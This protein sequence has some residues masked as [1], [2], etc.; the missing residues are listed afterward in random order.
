MPKFI[1]RFFRLSL[2]VS[3]VAAVNVGSIFPVQ[4]QDGRD[5]LGFA[6]SEICVPGIIDVPT[7]LQE[8]PPGEYEYQS[9]N[10]EGDEIETTD[11]DEILLSGNAQVVQGDRG[12]Y[13]DEIRF[14]KET[15]E[16]NANGNV[17]FYTGNGDEIRADSLD[18]VVDTFIGSAEDATIQF[19]DISPYF[20]EREHYNFEE[21]YSIFAP[22]RN[23][24]IEL[25]A[26]TG[27]PIDTNTY[28]RARATAETIE[29]EG[30]DFQ[31]MKNT[32][33]TT[34]TE[35]NG[36]ILLV[37]KEIELDHVTGIG[38]AKSMTVK[39]KK[40]PIFYFPTVS[41]P[42]NDERKTGF[43]FPGFGYDD[44][45]GTILA[46]PY[47]I[48]ISPQQDAT[49]TPRLLS[50]RGVQLYGEYRYLTHSSR[51]QIKVEYLPG[52]DLFDDDRHALSFDHY[53]SFNKDWNAD[54]DLQD[55]S[56]T[57]YLSDFATDVDVANATYIPQTANLNYFG[58]NL[59]FKAV[60]S[61][62]QRVN[63]SVSV[64]NQPYARLPQITLDLKAQEFSAF[65][66]GIDSQLTDF[67]HED[68]IS[69]EG[70]RARIL[71]YLTLPLEEIYG[72]VKPRVSVQAI[73]YDLDNNPTGESSPSTTVP[74]ASID[75]GLFFERIFKRSDKVFLHTLEPRL[76]YLNIPTELEQNDF[77]D[78]DTSG[79]SNSSYSHYFR[80]NRFFGG[81]RVGDAHQLSVG[82]SSRIIDDD[83]GV[84]RMNLSLGQVFYFDDREI[85]LTS[86]FEP[87]TEDTSDFLAEIS[88]A[89]TDD[90]TARA[91]ARW[92][93]EESELDFATLTANYFHSSRRNASIGYSYTVDSDEQF[94]LRLETPLGARWQFNGRADYS[95]VDSEIRTAEMGIVYD[96]CCWAL[97][98]TAQRYLRSGEFNDR[99]LVSFELDDLGKLST[100]L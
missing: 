81:D 59:R 25:D 67:N 93:A 50:N 9:T 11:G 74:M 53:Q 36:D 42:I 35:G 46:V 32:T 13:A 61:D 58:D 65:E 12:V 10:I 92:S 79:G 64:T 72:F 19:A 83:S 94:N 16:A 8:A 76:F 52:D 99:F 38:T 3:V 34:C 48:N 78:F 5:D 4:A 60:A 63:S 89:V 45:S 29:F 88:G 2:T 71:P 49:V 77:P 69:V 17:K 54:I 51:G 24:V 66:F 47:Y 44:V 86:D 98:L 100:R 21:D 70:T 73:S 91:F 26:P 39:F 57:D 30:K 7:A 43:L 27:P 55:V 28:V 68:D 90:W 40:V 14:N 97:G 15:Y 33:L 18:L 23:R 1:S 96:G 41:F 82:L 84:E 22:F 80:E 87:E 37:A 20:T 62:F 6:G 85:G 75:S 56:D 95:I 31:L